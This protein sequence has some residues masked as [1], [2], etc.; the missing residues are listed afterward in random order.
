MSG[1]WAKSV[2]ASQHATTGQRLDT[3]LIRFPRVILPEWNTHRVFSKNTSSGRAIPVSKMIDS[4][5]ED[6]YIPEVWTKN[7]RGMQGQGGHNELVDIGPLLSFKTPFFTT[8]ENAYLEGMHKAVA[9]AR[10]YAIAGYH[11]QIVNRL[12]EP[13]MW[14]LMVV[15][16]TEWDNFFELR[17]HGDAEPHMQI[18]AKAIRKTRD[19]ATVQIL[20][21]GAWH[22]PF[23]TDE[24]RY[25][26][27]GNIRALKRLSV[28]RCASTSYKTVDG[29]DMTQ[30]R[31]DDIY[32][33]LFGPPLHASPF[34]HVAQA[35]EAHKI[36]TFGP[37]EFYWE[38]KNP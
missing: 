31:A 36:H 34:E 20:H 7:E 38:Y 26:A 16:A 24:E 25:A 29:F 11:K 37:H 35:D 33:K 28:A 14:T 4:V 8:R 10:S 22:T 23:I 2:L 19:E 12:L 21:P 15:S 3:L 1:I 30:E 32:H 18:L 27:G 9:L 6:P 17:D 13:W 5:V